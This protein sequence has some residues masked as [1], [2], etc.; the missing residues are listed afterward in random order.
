MKRGMLGSLLVIACCSSS[1]LQA[2]QDSGVR[3]LAAH[4]ACDGSLFKALGAD[5]PRWQGEKSFARQGLLASFRVANRTPPEAYGG[6]ATLD[7]K[8]ARRIDGLPLSGWFDADLSAWSRFARFEVQFLSWGF[9]IDATPA[10]VRDWLRRA[11]P[12]VGRRLQRSSADKEGVYCVQER[13]QDERWQ[14]EACSADEDFPTEPTP[15]RWL[16]IR[17]A[18]TR[19]VLSCELSGSLPAPLLHQ[20]R[21]DLRH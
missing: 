5:A 18:D 16:V 19:T 7:F 10:D 9:Y 6:P 20:L 21:P 8:R 4:A 3:M 1:A 17:P 11:A 15:V 12:A 2:A 13:W 14:A